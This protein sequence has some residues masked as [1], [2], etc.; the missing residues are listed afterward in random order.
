[1]LKTI[2]SS[3]QVKGLVIDECETVAL[4][5]TFISLLD[6]ANVSSAVFNAAYQRGVSLEQIDRI[7]RLADDQLENVKLF[8]LFS[9]MAIRTD[10]RWLE[11][12]GRS[13]VGQRDTMNGGEKCIPFRI[14]GEILHK[15]LLAQRE[16]TLP[17]PDFTQDVSWSSFTFELL[18]LITSRGLTDEALTATSLEFE[19]GL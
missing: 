6:T 12:A 1:M 10:I 13:M 19:L 14:L 4:R 2:A 5:P 3:L 16:G 18:A 9:S 7:W 15:T 11:W 17:I 8:E